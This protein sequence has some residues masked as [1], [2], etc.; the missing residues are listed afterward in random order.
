MK[1]QFVFETEEEAERALEKI[2]EEYPDFLDPKERTDIQS[3]FGSED[4][5][6][7]KTYYRLKPITKKKGGY[8]IEAVKNVLRKTGV[9]KISGVVFWNHV[10]EKWISHSSINWSS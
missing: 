8:V 3:R 5:T 2:K 7:S 9:E 10:K 1:D 6:E 4:Q